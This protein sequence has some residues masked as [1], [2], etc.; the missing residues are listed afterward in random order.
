MGAGSRGRV[1][2]A[3]AMAVAFGPLTPAFSAAAPHRAEP[4]IVGGTGAVQV[5][6]FM[7]SLQDPGGHHFCGGSLVR[8]DLVV[9]AAH[10]VAGLAP[11][12]LRLRIGSSDRTTGGE[13]TRAAGITVH[14]GYQGNGPGDDIA[15]VRLAGPVRAAPVAIAAGSGG[16]GTRTRILGW[17]QT[18]AQPD[19]CDLP[20]SLQQLDTQIVDPSRC[21]H[22]DSRHEL[23]TDNPH[24]NAGA[25]YGDSGGPQIRLVQG[26]WQLVGATSRSG[27]D[28]QVC[29]TAPAI[30]TDV[31]AYADW[32]AQQAGT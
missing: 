15:V 12:D 18:C 24:G 17:G 16:P 26:A 4:F 5:Y 7:A 13:L 3:V 19:A 28:D 20:H 6:P 10:C 8:P 14:P 32:I 9:T 25:C 30:Y 1:L 29:A 2:L 23:C 31:T 11:E 21:A 22:I 27:N